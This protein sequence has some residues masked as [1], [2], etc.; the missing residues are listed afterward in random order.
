MQG[1]RRHFFYTTTST[2]T[3]WKLR[4]GSVVI[5]ILTVVLTRSLWAGQI[6]RSL[7]CPEKLAPSDVILVEDFDTN[8]MV[9]KRAGELQ[10]A[11]YASRAL[12]H[13]SAGGDAAVAD[14]VSQ[15]IAEVM[16]RQARLGSWDTIPV[17]TAEPITLNAAR[18]VRDRLLRE[19]VKSLIVVTA[20]FRSRRTSLVYHAVLRDADMRIH[21]APVFSANAPNH[22]TA[23]W[24]GIQEV[25]EESLK[26]QYYRFYVIPVLASRAG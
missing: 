18:Q 22:W 9:F 20:G 21:C 13:V 26:L 5:L 1:W 3:T 24:H 16:A 11:G 6:G 25:A 23:R 2:K 15:G 14:P 17:R 4:L 19:H 12:V 7:V 10:R 8:Y